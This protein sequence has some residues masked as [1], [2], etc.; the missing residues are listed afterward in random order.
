MNVE[1]SDFTIK[2]LDDGTP[3]KYLDKLKMKYPDLSIC[4]S[5]FYEEKSLAVENHP[6]KM[7]QKIPIDLWVSEIKKATE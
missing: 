7:N 3:Q 4:K 2:I 6:D 5:D 1:N